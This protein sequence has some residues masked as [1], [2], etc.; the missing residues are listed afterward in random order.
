MSLGHN[1]K[2]LKVEYRTEL[3][4]KQQ[5]PEKSAC[6]RTGILHSNSAKRGE[7]TDKQM[8]HDK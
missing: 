3:Q 8:V 5:K 6:Y 7:E 2:K 4:H 1:K